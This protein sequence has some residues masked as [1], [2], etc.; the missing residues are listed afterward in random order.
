LGALK[1]G[2]IMRAI[3]GIEVDG[4]SFGAELGH[5]AVESILYYIPDTEENA[6][7]FAALAKHPYPRVRERV[8]EKRNLDQA[9]LMKLADDTDP[10]VVASVAYSEGFKEEASLGDL[11][12]IMEKEDEQTLSNIISYCGS[13]S[14]ISVDEIAQAIKDLNIQNPYVL[15]QAAQSY[16]MPASFIEELTEH[17]DASVSTAAKEQLNNR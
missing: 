9:T 17:P 1:K 13:F 12:K 10:R 11:K 6:G 16:E 2:E 3:L 5:E 4:E 7:I 15:L 8:A 14:K